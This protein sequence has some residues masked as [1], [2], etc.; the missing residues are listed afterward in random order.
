MHA[1]EHRLALLHWIFGASVVSTA[2][3][4]THNF[5]AVDQYPPSDLISTTGVRV[6]IVVAWP[7]FTALGVLGVRRYAQGRLTA[8]HLLLAVYALMPL[9][10]L[11]HYTTGNPD[12]APFFYATIITDGLL[13]LAVLAFVVWSN[14]VTQRGAP[15]TA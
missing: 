5:V 10:T 13:G 7:A 15:V 1:P 9:T 11:G 12:I 4:F 6:A 14:R 2:I 3:H 8:A